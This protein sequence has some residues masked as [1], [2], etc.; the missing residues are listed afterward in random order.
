[1][2]RQ[3]Q[4]LAALVAILLLSLVYAR[5]RTPQQQRVAPGKVPAT[6]APSPRPATTPPLQTTASTRIETPLVYR[7]LAFPEA[8]PTEVT[9]KRNLFTPLQVSEAKIAAKKA[10]AIKPPPPPPPPPPPTPQE[11][12]RGELS[13]YKPIGLLKKQGRLIAFI[14]RG[15][16]IRLVRV[17]DTLIAGYQ[18][19][20]ISDDRLLMS[21]A[22]GDTLSLG[23]R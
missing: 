12:A 17:G 15:G 9:V 23:M 11:L 13:Q 16:Q 1:M 21:S 10:A 14:A 20:S 5:F 2:K 4:I 6:A 18:V 19:T 3:R 7:P 22:D 8:E